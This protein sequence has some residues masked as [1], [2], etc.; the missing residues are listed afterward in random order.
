[1]TGM[2]I[3]VALLA[4]GCASAGGDGREQRA[5]PPPIA[6]SWVVSTNVRMDG[7]SRR[8]LR[9]VRYHVPFTAIDVIPDGEGISPNVHIETTGVTGEQL[10]REFMRQD[11]RYAAVVEGDW[12]V[13]MP[14][15]AVADAD[16]PLNLVVD[17]IKVTK[18]SMEELSSA[19]HLQLKRSTGKEIY[20][21]LENA[22]L[23]NKLISIEPEHLTLDLSSRT[24]RAILLEGSA[25]GGRSLEFLVSHEDGKTIVNYFPHPL[26]PH[27]YVVSRPYDI[28][29][30]PDIL[31][32]LERRRREGLATPGWGQ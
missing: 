3:V 18:V 22:N 2:L 17:N 25:Q 10:I 5:P 28:P 6:Y 26:G 29:I 7:S 27:W 16:Y 14:T 20:F 31:A 1:M 21:R 8:G 4:M 15:G 24:V 13:V 30:P 12:V 32:V 23:F 9:D 19:I 11:P